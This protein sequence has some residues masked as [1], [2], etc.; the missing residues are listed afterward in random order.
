MKTKEVE[1]IK[2]ARTRLDISPGR[3]VLARTSSD[4]QNFMKSTA[5]DV[6]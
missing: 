5:S 1:G 6:P 4:E 2:T 3:E